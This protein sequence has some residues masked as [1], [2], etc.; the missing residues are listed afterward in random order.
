[1]Y[2][3]LDTTNVCHHR[4]LSLNY[5]DYVVLLG[6]RLYLTNVLFCYKCSTLNKKILL[7]QSETD[8]ISSSS[9][10]FLAEV[11]CSRCDIVTRQKRLFPFNYRNL[12]PLEPIQRRK[13]VGIVKQKKKRNQVAVGINDD[14]FGKSMAI[15]SP[16][17]PFFCVLCQV[18]ISASKQSMF[19][20]QKK[21][22][23]HSTKEKLK[24]HIHQQQSTSFLCSHEKY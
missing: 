5:R 23:C 8:M 14:L 18:R 9:L 3:M 21:D 2:P 13:M 1:M 20:C 12:L 24:T 22:R 17:R 11:T 15:A 6:T 16:S 10:S 7:V 19:W 4:F